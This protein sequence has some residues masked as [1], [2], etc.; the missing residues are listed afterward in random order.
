MMAK[1]RSQHP[2]ADSCRRRRRRF[3][4]AGQLQ[5]EQRWLPCALRGHRRRSLEV[6]WQSLPDLIVLD[7]L[8]PNVDGLEVCRLLKSDAQT[9][10]IPI[11][12][13][14]AKS[15]EADV[16][17]GLELGADDYLTKPFC[18]ASCWPYQSPVAA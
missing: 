10:H 18:L 13:L 1:S 3:A 15:E 11:I 7:L 6:G 16:V 8:L 2:P 5:P 12:M 17:A 4:G 9:Q 14:T